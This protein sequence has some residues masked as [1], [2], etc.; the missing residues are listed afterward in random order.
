M[1]A[2]ANAR[3]DNVTWADYLT[4]TMALGL[5]KTGGRAFNTPCCPPNSCYCYNRGL[6]AVFNNEAEHQ[7][8]TRQGDKYLYDND[9]MFTT[10]I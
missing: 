5:T 1:S 9:E 4:L 6:V 3:A 10:E 8:E 7:K 2:L